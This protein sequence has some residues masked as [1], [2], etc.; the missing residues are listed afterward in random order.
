MISFHLAV[1]SVFFL[2]GSLANPL[3]LRRFFA[4]QQSSKGSFYMFLSACY[5]RMEKAGSNTEL[6]KPKGALVN[7]SA[8]QQFSCIE[9]TVVNVTNL[10]VILHARS[11]L[12]V[13]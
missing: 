3:G 4:Q 12:A 10:H 6:L 7:F 2:S 11:L 8:T 9:D 1:C 13:R 5:L